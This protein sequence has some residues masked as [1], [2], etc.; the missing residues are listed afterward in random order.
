[1][2][3]KQRC[4]I[5]G[6]NANITPSQTFIGDQINCDRCGKLIV[7]E[8]ALT[9]FKGGDGYK[10]TSSLYYYFTH[11]KKDNKKIYLIVDS[12]KKNNQYNIVTIQELI[13][14]YPKT[15]SEKIDKILLSWD[16]IHNPDSLYI[17]NSELF[18]KYYQMF[19]IK[20]DPFMEQGANTY[21]EI[22]KQIEYL[23]NIMCEQ[24]LLKKKDQHTSDYT[25]GYMGWQRID[26][27]QKQNAKHN[28]GFIAM[29]FPEDKSMD[30]T[31]EAIK[32]VFIETGYQISI[33]D[34][35]HH[36]N[37]IVPEILYEIETSDFIVADLTGNRNGVYYEAGYA[38][39]LG[40]EVILTVDK[41]EIDEDYDN[42]PH[43]DVAQINQIRY[44]DLDDLKIQLFN[45]ITVTVGN[46]KN[47]NAKLKIYAPNETEI[48]VE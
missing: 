31:R 3:K 26:E 19:F 11:Y 36:N 17:R 5:C 27:L 23:L 6:E 9:H 13:N 18:I 14:L 42:A 38:L 41:N 43:F 30:P 33:I 15:F 7:E 47:P 24:E 2:S 40:K 35:K 4:Y 39:G 34:E 45:R 1:M 22:V 46:I 8:S 12:E 16:A 20:H 21:G 28:K 37:Q 48:E 44:Q 25:I 32:D 29:W 10:Y